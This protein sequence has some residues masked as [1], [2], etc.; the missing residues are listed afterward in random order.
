MN[1]THSD[2]TDRFYNQ[3]SLESNPAQSPE[4]TAFYNELQQWIDCG[5]QYDRGFKFF[6]GLCHNLR[7]WASRNGITWLSVMTELDLQFKHAG[8]DFC[9]PF[10]SERSHIDSRLSYLDE[11]KRKMIY[12]NQARLDWIKSHTTK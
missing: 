6:D 2:N 3:Y 12:K 10:N 7:L 11:G 4:L 8:L 5:C 9:Y 1:T